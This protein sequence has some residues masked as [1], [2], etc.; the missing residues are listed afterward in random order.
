MQ[1][2]CLSL[3]DSLDD[4]WKRDDRD[5]VEAHF[6]AKLRE[7]EIDHL[8][9]NLPKSYSWCL[10]AYVALW[11]CGPR[12]SLLNL[13]HCDFRSKVITYRLDERVLTV[14]DLEARRE[15]LEHL[16]GEAVE[17]VDGAGIFKHYWDGR[18]LRE[19]TAPDA[20]VVRPKGW[21]LI[22]PVMAAPKIVVSPPPKACI[23]L[24]YQPP[25]PGLRVVEPAQSAVADRANVL[26]RLRSHA[27]L[28]PKPFEP[29]ESKKLR[30]FLGWWARGEDPNYVV[31]EFAF[32][33]VGSEHLLTHYWTLSDRDK[34][35]GRQF[36][37]RA[38]AEL[39]GRLNST[40]YP[41]MAAAVAAWRCGL[42]G[43]LETSWIEL[44]ACDF[45]NSVVTYVGI[46]QV[47]R[48]ADFEPH[49]DYFETLWQGP[50]E[51]CVSPGQH[52]L[53]NGLPAVEADADAP[54][55]HDAGNL[56]ERGPEPTRAV[57]VG[58]R[59]ANVVPVAD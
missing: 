12:V 55:L 11:D 40:T 45:R 22:R 41:A 26:E 2:H 53:R 1:L 32:F 5:A 15:A 43:S 42:T 46:G 37:W 56:A 29:I 31:L 20:V 14:A 34:A 8:H 28:K 6:N 50:V 59:P 18:T 52:E 54:R 33:M 24:P 47:L 10:R 35:R 17:F 57:V 7:L 3:A 23:N 16:W 49:R 38:I 58:N 9:R 27:A 21:K 30:E 25:P 44:N 39:A 13:H 48:P 19:F 51:A 36:I 4:F